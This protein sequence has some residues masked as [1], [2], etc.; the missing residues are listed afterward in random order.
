MINI[1]TNKLIKSDR[2]LSP[3]FR[4][5]F[6]GEH[7]GL[8]G[9]AQT[10]TMWTFPNISPWGCIQAGPIKW[11]SPSKE[12]SAIFG[13]AHFLEGQIIVGRKGPG[14]VPTRF[15]SVGPK[16]ARI[17]SK[18]QVR[19]WSA[20]WGLGQEILP[21]WGQL[22]SVSILIRSPRVANDTGNKN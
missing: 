22:L 7:R 4:R 20:A 11:L 10:Y 18:N 14:T 3:F 15:K 6:L 13:R 12:R 19:K 8:W 2:K 9:G 16:T 1:L 5:L 17:N 21:G